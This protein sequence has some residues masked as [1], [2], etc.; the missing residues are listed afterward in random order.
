MVDEMQAA[1]PQSVRKAKAHYQQRV[2][3]DQP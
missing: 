1:A 3:A 2:A